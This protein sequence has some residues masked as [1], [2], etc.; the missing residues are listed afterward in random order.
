MTSVSF[1]LPAGDTTT[2]WDRMHEHEA[3]RRAKG[4]FEHPCAGSI[5]KNNRS[6]GAPSGAIIDRLGLRGFSI[7]RAKV[8]DRHANIVQN[9]G[10]ASASEIRAVIEHVA[11]EVE[12]QLGFRLE[13]EVLYVGDW[14]DA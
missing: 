14:E 10:G 12:R 2:L 13:R 7:G 4:H 1:T 6:F 3:D 8:S 9:T 11:R 5:F